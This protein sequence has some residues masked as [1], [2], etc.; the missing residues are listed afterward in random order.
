[1]NLE[2]LAPDRTLFS[3]NVD[4]VTLPGLGGKF[5]V[6]RNHAPIIA[7]LTSGTIFYSEDER[8]LG[9][10]VIESGFCEV[11]KNSVYVCVEVPEDRK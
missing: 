9:S 11:F 2:I 8:P 1:M 5:T 3:G 6:L 4:A 7:A 10:I